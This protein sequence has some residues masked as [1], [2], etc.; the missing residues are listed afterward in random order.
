VRTSQLKKLYNLQLLPKKDKKFWEEFMTQFT[1]QLEDSGCDN[2][3]AAD[4]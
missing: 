3:S 1:Q 2:V 4:S